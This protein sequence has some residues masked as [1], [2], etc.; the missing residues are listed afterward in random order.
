MVMFGAGGVLAELLDDVAILPA[1]AHPDAIR[2]KLRRLRIA[3]LLAGFRGKPACDIDALVDAIHRLSLFVADFDKEIAELDIN[4]L[5]VAATGRGV[6][7]VDARMRI[8]EQNIKA[9]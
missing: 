2:E 3:K 1:P 6:V 4:P 7:A 8:A 9:A 5:I